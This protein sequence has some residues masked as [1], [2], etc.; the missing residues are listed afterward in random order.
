MTKISPKKRDVRLLDTR[1]IAFFLSLSSAKE[2]KKDRRSRPMKGRRFFGRC[3][4]VGLDPKDREE[5]KIETTNRFWHLPVWH[6]SLL[7]MNLG[8]DISKH[9]HGP[10]DIV[11]VHQEEIW[12]LPDR[13]PII[14]STKSC[15]KEHD[16]TLGQLLEDEE[17]IK[18]QWQGRLACA[19]AGERIKT[20]I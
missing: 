1:I 2:R 9:K 11:K 19:V 3:E 12:L 6:K 4:T 13:E 5:K 14:S 10:R 7:L 18:G 20:K 17:R 8:D 15:P 16:A